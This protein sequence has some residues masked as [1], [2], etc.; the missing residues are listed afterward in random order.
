MTAVPLGRG[1]YERKYAGAP[2]IEL[3]NRWLESN[4]ANLREGTSVLAR[5]GTTQIEPPFSPGTYV[6]S[7][8]TM[9]GNYSLAGLF[10][11]SLFV[12]CGENIYRINSDMTITAITGTIAGTGTPE[13]AWQAGAGYERL[14]ISDGTL[15]QYYE[16]LS[17]ATGTV[18]NAVPPIV[19]GTD[20]FEVGGVYY[21]WGPVT[22]AQG[23]ATFAGGVPTANQ[24]I[25]I[26]T[27]VYTFVKAATQPFEVT[28]G[29]TAQTCAVA[30]LD[31]V[32]SNSLLVTATANLAVVTVTAKLSGS[33]GNYTFTKTASNV[34][35]SGSGT[36]T[37]GT[38][39]AD[40]SS[41]NPYVVNPIN[42]AGGTDPM[43]QLIL[44]IMSTGTPGVDY[45]ASITGPN[46]YVR[47]LGDGNTPVVAVI[48]Q[49]LTPGS[50]GDS[51]TLTVT[52]GSALTVTGSGTLGGGGL[53][54][55]QGCTMPDGVAPQ[56]V[57]QV[58]SYVLVSVADTQKFYWVNPGEITI[59]PLDFASK[60]S[61]PDPIQQ[62]R[63]VGDQVLIMGAKSTENWYATGVF[64]APFAPIQGR[65]YARGVIEGTPV[66][67]DDGIFLVGDDGRVYSIGFQPGDNTDAAWGVA[68]VSNNGIE[69]RIRYQLRREAGLTP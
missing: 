34:T 31:V 32:N 37:G 38:V 50:A 60:E 7:P 9:R 55:L 5:P 17:S 30:F 47:A 8:G 23:T 49:A 21:E 13:V 68:R 64:T 35:L 61:S 3:L 16:G 44:A 14:W 24:T 54:V 56:S 42:A 53:H 27:E 39:T 25:T 43:A 22:N 66:V 6:P 58:S 48:L 33:I 46:T 12:V 65:V 51:I 29:P 2:V 59:D 57:T 62:M 19:N 67:V 40:G 11:D 36:M 1:A 15:L 4:P 26:G 69:E 28:I 20:I 63:A 52:G 45:S 41:G 10:D 18:T